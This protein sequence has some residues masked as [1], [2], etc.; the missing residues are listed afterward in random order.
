MCFIDMLLLTN[1]IMIYVS[2]CGN[3]MFHFG[4]VNST[5]SSSL[6]VH[7]HYTTTIS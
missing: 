3:V 5:H 7:T 6:F 4:R 2:G 1:D